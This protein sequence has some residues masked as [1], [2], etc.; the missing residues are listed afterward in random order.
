MASVLSVIVTSAFI[1]YILYFTC[2][3]SKNYLL[4][5]SVAFYVSVLMTAYVLSLSR[6]D[7]IKSDLLVQEL[8]CG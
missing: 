1:V 8:T 5:V 3:A 6:T 7:I 2:I 4:M